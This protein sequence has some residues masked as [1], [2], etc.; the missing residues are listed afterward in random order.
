MRLKWPE[1]RPWINVNLG[2][3][4]LGKY[5]KVVVFF[6]IDLVKRGFSE[7][8]FGVSFISLFQSPFTKHVF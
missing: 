3:P 6:N 7:L 2:Q 1:M 8:S 5:F 4:V